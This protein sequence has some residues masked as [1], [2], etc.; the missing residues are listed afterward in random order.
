MKARIALVGVLV[1]SLAGVPAAIAQQACP[2]EL[3]A[4]KAALQSASSA[5]RTAAGFEGGSSEAPRTAA[6]YQGGSGEAPRS[7]AGYQGGSG[8]AP[9][10]AAGYQGGSGEAPRSAAG[11][12]GGSGEAPRSAAGYQGGSGEA[13]RAMAGAQVADPVRI[14]QARALIA[15]SEQACAKGD[16]ATSMQKAKAALEAL[17]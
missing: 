10:S 5:P 2:A 13:P 4:A 16:A 3:T 9:R 17:K 11:Y 6:G 8:E 14:N 12:Q 1:G 7:A 15:E